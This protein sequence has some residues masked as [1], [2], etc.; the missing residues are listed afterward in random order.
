M[1]GVCVYVHY[2]DDGPS[3]PCGQLVSI[4]SPWSKLYRYEGDDAY[5][6][7][8]AFMVWVAEHPVGSGRRNPRVEA[9]F[10]EAEDG[11]APVR[12]NKETP[13]A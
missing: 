1:S 7:A 11:P 2:R 10:Y 13:D 4:T 12:S 6:D 3:G 8:R 9:F 5:R